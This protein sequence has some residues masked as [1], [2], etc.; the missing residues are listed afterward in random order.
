MMTTIFKASYN[1]VAWS[2]PHLI[3]KSSAFVELIFIACYMIN[4]FID[5]PVAL[6]NVRY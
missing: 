5:N 1:F 3:A 4:R 2:I 6:L